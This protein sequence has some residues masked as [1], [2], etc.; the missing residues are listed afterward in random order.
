VVSSLACLAPGCQLV[1][2][3]K[4]SPVLLACG[5]ESDKKEIRR[6]TARGIEVHR[7]SAATRYERTLDLLERLGSL[8]MT[9]VLVEGG[10]Q[11]FGSLFDARQINEVHVFIAPKLFGGDKAPSPIG[12][13]GISEVAAALSLEQMQMQMLGEDIYLHGRVKS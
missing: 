9:N 12:G 5:P 4:E 6:L 1:K 13:A 3:A 2:T 8:Q 7:F 11:L 10:S